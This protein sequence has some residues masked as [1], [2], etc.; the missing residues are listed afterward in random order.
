MELGGHRGHEWFL[1]PDAQDECLLDTCTY[2]TLFYIYLY[3]HCIYT[4]NINKPGP[5]RKQRKGARGKVVKERGKGGESRRG[6]VRERRQMRRRLRWPT[7]SLHNAN[8][9]NR[10]HRLALNLHNK[11]PLFKNSCLKKE[12]RVSDQ[13]RPKQQNKRRLWLFTGTKKRTRR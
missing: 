8:G 9:H 4:V 7:L 5:C 12:P 13:S 10:T 3:I 6:W 11:I 2:I 1:H